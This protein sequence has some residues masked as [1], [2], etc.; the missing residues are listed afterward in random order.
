MGMLRESLYPSQREWAADR[1]AS[2]DWKA[3]PQVVLALATAARLDPAASVR[4][5]CIR[6]L[7]KMEANSL[8]AIAALEAAK[9]DSEP[10]VRA[11]AEQA[12]ASLVPAAP[13][14]VQPVSGSEQK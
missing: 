12:L 9:A 4:A 13:P 1:L 6:S 8:P 10:T 7:A 11:A 14:A 3:H 5:G 2:L